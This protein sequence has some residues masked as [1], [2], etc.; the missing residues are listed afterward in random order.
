MTHPPLALTLDLDDTLWP[1]WPAIA[2]AEE[3]LHAWLR[4]HARATA[5]RFDTAA[6]RALRDELAA[7]HPD[8]SHD[9]TRI[10]LESLRRALCLAGDDPSLAEPAFAVFFQ[11]RQEVE[12]FGDVPPALERLAARFPIVALTN[13]NAELD[14]IGLT[15]WFRDCVTARNFG[16]G[17][18]DRRI[19]EEACRRL[20]VPPGRVLHVGDDAVLDVAGALAAGLQAA[21]VVRPEI[22]PRPGPAPTGT[23]HVVA[24]LAELADRLGA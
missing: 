18:P 15:P 22:H 14:R 3:R 12:L 9:L 8:W 16:V 2:R 13:G 23:H 7:R 11:A 1:V 19:F 10:R 20:G 5:A 17:K 4:T 6:L 24:S 21:W